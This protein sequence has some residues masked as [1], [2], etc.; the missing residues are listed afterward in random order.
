MTRIYKSAGEHQKL[1]FSCEKKKKKMFIRDNNL[2]HICLNAFVKKK[3]TNREQKKN[4]GK[5]PH[6]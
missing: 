4:K 6:T 3:K 2:N 5:R 1:Q